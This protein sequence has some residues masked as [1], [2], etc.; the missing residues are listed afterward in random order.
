[1]TSEYQIKKRFAKSAKDLRQGN[2]RRERRN[3]SVKLS[4]N[5]FCALRPASAGLYDPE[6]ICK[7]DAEGNVIQATR[8]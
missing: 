2:G 3:I 4:D 6:Y 5:L 1:M 8:I 7:V